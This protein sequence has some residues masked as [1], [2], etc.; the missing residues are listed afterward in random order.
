MSV[1]KEKNDMVIKIS[2][3]LWYAIYAVLCA[4]LVAAFMVLTGEIQIIYHP[5]VP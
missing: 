3:I 4:N 1:V 5:L 2:P